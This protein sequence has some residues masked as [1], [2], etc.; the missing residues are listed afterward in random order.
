MTIESGSE[1]TSR[2]YSPFELR[3]QEFQDAFLEKRAVRLIE[4]EEIRKTDEAR[5]VE[6][7]ELEVAAVHKTYEATTQEALDKAR[8]EWGNTI[9]Q[10]SAYERFIE[11]RNREQFTAKDSGKTGLIRRKEFGKFDGDKDNTWQKYVS[12]KRIPVNMLSLQN[13]CGGWA[14]EADFEWLGSLLGARPCSIQWLPRKEELVRIKTI[15]S[16]VHSG[17]GLP[18][19][20]EIGCG[21]GLLSYLMA[22][23]EG[24][25]VVGMDPDENLLLDDQMYK[26]DWGSPEIQV[27]AYTH[28]NLRLIAGTSRT[29]LEAFKD[30]PTDLVVSSWMPED[31]DLIPDISALKPKAIVLMYPDNEIYQARFA[32]SVQTYRRAYRWHGPSQEDVIDFSR[33]ANAVSYGSELEIE[34]GN[35]VEIWLREDANPTF[36][37]RIRIPKKDKYPWETASLKEVMDRFYWNLFHNP[38]YSERIPIMKAGFKKLL[39][40]EPMEKAG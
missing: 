5:L 29:M 14:S 38:K 17:P 32:D 16:V 23:E 1:G 20:V 39:E 22:A 13:I 2:D 24:L 25:S 36:P 3:V 31:I 18:G 27:E 33:V 6:L 9:E 28:P 7:K 35:T 21:C 34:N 10:K 12:Q 11:R 26:A 30:T 40:V 8:E 15:A 4:R 37:E 19:I